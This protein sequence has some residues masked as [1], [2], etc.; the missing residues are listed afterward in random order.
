MQR[1]LTTSKA[2][3]AISTNIQLE[4]I[5]QKIKTPI[6]QLLET[7]DFEADDIYHKYLGKPLKESEFVV[8]T[9][10]KYLDKILN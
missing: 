10:K 8:D 7:D 4:L 3:D 9:K 5:K 1:Q 6:C 2:L